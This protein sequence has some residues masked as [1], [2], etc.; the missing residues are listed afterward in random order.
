MSAD[1]SGVLWAQRPQICARGRSSGPA[2]AHPGG[3]LDGR[4]AAGDPAAG[5]PE[6]RA[7]PARAPGAPPAARRLTSPRALVDAPCPG[8]PRRRPRPAAAAAPRPSRP[9]SGGVGGSP[10]SPPARRAPGAQG[11]PPVTAVSRS[12][13][14]AGGL[15]CAR[16]RRL[17]RAARGFPLQRGRAARGRRIRRPRRSSRMKCSWRGFRI[18]GSTC[19]TGLSRFVGESADAF[20]TRPKGGLRFRAPGSRS[21]A[22]RGGPGSRDPREGRGD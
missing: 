13:A 21:G 17:P 2:A 12:E 4:G 19:W 14:A 20:S 1:R 22:G 9:P 6:R 10:K 15:R 11:P 16:P 5:R 8:G 3:A 18:A 7:P